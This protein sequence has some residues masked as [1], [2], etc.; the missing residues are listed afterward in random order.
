MD[1]VSYYNSLIKG[2]ANF[3]VIRSDVYSLIR[4]LGRCMSASEYVFCSEEE[5]RNFRGTSI[6]FAI[7]ILL[8]QKY[9]DTYLILCLT[10]VNKKILYSFSKS[11]FNENKQLYFQTLMG[12]VKNMIRGAEGKIE[13]GDKHPIRQGFELMESILNNVG[14]DGGLEAEARACAQDVLDILFIRLTDNE[15]NLKMLLEFGNN[16]RMEV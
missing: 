2:S 12:Y 10:K 13:D 3:D 1:I 4:V 7:E 16:N 8:D 15:A 5:R 11:D 9:F 14:L 6:Q